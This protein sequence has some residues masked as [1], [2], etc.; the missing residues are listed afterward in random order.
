MR[1]SK[2]SKICSII[3]F[4]VLFLTF[5]VIN[6]PV[7]ANPP[8][9]IITVYGYKIQCYHDVFDTDGDGE[10]RFQCSF[11]S[12]LSPKYTTSKYYC[13]E[14][15]TEIRT[16][17]IAAC[18]L[19]NGDY[20]YLKVY[21]DDP[22][23]GSHDTVVN[24]KVKSVSSLTYGYNYITFESDDQTRDVFCTFKIHKKDNPYS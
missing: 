13:D 16:E 6:V 1:R 3:F 2:Q 11:E 7:K 22:W 21:E 23:P 14:Y 12:D 15:D 5:F 17:L 19:Y 10:F 18:A 9:Y 8:D 4:G 20:V 24:W